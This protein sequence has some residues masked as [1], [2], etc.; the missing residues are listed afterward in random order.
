MPSAKG[1]EVLLLH[2]EERAAALVAARNKTQARG[3]MPRKIQ[4]TPGEVISR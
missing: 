2:K 4:T 1:H 3:S